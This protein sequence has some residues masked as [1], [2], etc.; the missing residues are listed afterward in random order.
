MS[1]HS[2]TETGPGNRGSKTRQ[3]LRDAY[4]LT[5]PY[6]R[7]EERWTARLALFG[8]IA[9]ALIQVGGSALINFWYGQFYD[10]LQNKDLN[11]FIKL[12]L[13]YRWDENGFMP[14]FVPIVTILV[15]LAVVRVYM[16]QYLQISWRRWMTNHFIAQWLAGRAY[17]TIGL[18]TG[19][20]DPGTDNPD[21]RIA[22]DIRDFTSNTITLGISFISRITSLFSFALILWSLSGTL[23]VFGIPIPGYMLWGAVLYAVVGTWLTHLVGRPLVPL[24][25]LQ[26]KAEADFRFAL[27]RFRENAE[28]VALH[29]GEREESTV[30]TGRFGEVARNWFRIMHRTVKLNFL[31]DTYEQAAVI[32][33]FILGAPRYFA[34]E[35]ALGGLMRIVSAFG[36]VQ[37]AL[38]WFITSYDSLATW[39]ATVNRVVGF[40][41]AIVA[42]QAIGSQGPALVSGGDGISLHDAQIRLPDGQPLLDRSN[43]TLSRGRSV[44]IAGRSGAGKSTLFRAIAGIW[45]FGS[46]RIERAPGTYLFLPQR[47]Y[48]PLGNLRHAVTYPESA[49]GFPDA[50]IRQA[51]TDAGL[52]ALAGRLDEEHNWAQT[53]SGGELQRLAVARA[54][55]LRPDWLFLDEATSSLDPE[56][57]ADLYTALRRRLPKTTMVSIAHRPDVARY[58]DEALVFQRRPGAPGSIERRQPATMESTAA[59]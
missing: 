10:S 36:R 4:R 1:E 49:S 6:F 7:S 33:P 53:L 12:L 16:Q 14:G 41:N 13:L 59:P 45:P 43:V 26:Q 9:L 38:S 31:T 2:R 30:L 8:I 34:G 52:S 20:G 18:T 23:V 39:R 21:Q 32:F 44:A 50:E 54:L 40:Q 58:H 42:A 22:E 25:F 56:A 27:V 47:P 5:I 48:I 19:M 17:Y 37:D 3:L 28:G 51:L 29:A 35:I 24:N 46:G 55:L 57:E 15:P 11:S